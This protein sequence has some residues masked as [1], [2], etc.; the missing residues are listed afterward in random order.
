M[1]H[2]EHRLRIEFDTPCCSGAVLDQMVLVA[3]D[4][5]MP[6]G[7]GENQLIPPSF[8]CPRRL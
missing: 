2:T 6:C 4:P 7:D 8:L 5:F 1:S 3:H